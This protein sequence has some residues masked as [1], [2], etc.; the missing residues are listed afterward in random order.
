MAI[1]QLPLVAK[2]LGNVF[3]VASFLVGRRF[4]YGDAMAKKYVQA[5][6]VAMNQAVQKSPFLTP[7]EHEAELTAM[8]DD[9]ARLVL[10]FK[11]EDDIYVQSVEKEILEDGLVGTL[12]IFSKY[13]VVVELTDGV[14]A[15]AYGSG[16]NL[17]S[18]PDKTLLL[19]EPVDILKA[20]AYIRENDMAMAVP[21]IV[22]IEQI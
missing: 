2:L 17:I 16:Y 11:K 9:G 6:G 10:S 3:R 14:C 5:D 13:K 7:G 18:Y 20:V 22:R 8:H 15:V 4:F 12:G 21:K 19:E 1:R